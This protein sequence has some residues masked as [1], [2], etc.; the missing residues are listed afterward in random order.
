[1]HLHRSR[2]IHPGISGLNPSH[3][4][5]LSF[6]HDAFSPTALPSFLPPSRTCK[7]QN[8]ASFSLRYDSICLLRLFAAVSA[9]FNEAIRYSVLR[10]PSSVPTSSSS[11]S[12]M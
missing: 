2:S 1:M 7:H 9:P 6:A 12:V 8:P 5:V 10:P 3:A 4:Y 11:S